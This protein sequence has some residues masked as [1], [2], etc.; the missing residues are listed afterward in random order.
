MNF[1]ECKEKIVGPYVA[2]ITPFNADYTLDLEGLRENVRFLMKNGIKEGK[3]MLLAAGAGGEFPSLSVGERK[4]VLSHVAEETKG[5]VPLIFSAQHTVLDKVIDLCKHAEKEGAV[6]VQLSPPY[7]WGLSR[8]EVYRF[9]K[10]VVEKTNVGIMVYHGGATF[11]NSVG[12]DYKLMS[13]LT[14]IENVITAKYASSNMYEYMK[15]VRAFSNRLAIIDNQY[16]ATGFGHMLGAR[17]FLSACGN[18]VPKRSLAFWELL[19]EG[20]YKQAVEMS[21]QL[22]IP[23]YQ[24][25]QEVQARGLHGE[26]SI[27]KPPCRLVGLHAGQARPPYN[28]SLPEDLE[29]KLEDILVK[30]GVKIIR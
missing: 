25:I 3:G 4:Q 14:E 24:W 12:I 7:Y 30:A 19:E 20:R 6:S 21:L 28:L 17:G 1:E 13:M 8:G 18:F 26:G 29:K 27:L 9:Y 15:V 22:E 2:L 23:F 5:K 11:T 16:W 10:K